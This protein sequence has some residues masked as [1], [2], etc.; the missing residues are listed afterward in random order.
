MRQEAREK[1]LPG[2]FRGKVFVVSLLGKR[3]FVHCPAIKF[4]QDYGR[5]TD[6]QVYCGQKS[7]GTAY[8][9]NDHDSDVHNGFLNFLLFCEVLYLKTSHAIL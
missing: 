7:G 6:C 9:C 2:R 3:N 1:H 5:K 8:D 4:P